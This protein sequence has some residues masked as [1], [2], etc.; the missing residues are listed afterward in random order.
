M[1]TVG[2]R[3]RV[4]KFGVLAALVACGSA[5]GGSAGGSGSTSGS[6]GSLGATTGGSAA[7]GAGSGIVASGVSVESTGA[8]GSGTSIGAATGAETTS[9]S[10]A[11]AGSTTGDVNASGTTMASGATAAPSSGSVGNGYSLVDASIAGMVGAGS[12]EPTSEPTTK[13]CPNGCTTDAAMPPMMA[14]GTPT[15]I[16]D[17]STGR[18]LYIENQCSYTIW[19][20]GGN[21]MFGG[22]PLKSGPG[23]AFV[24]TFPGGFSGRLWPRSGC[25]AGGQNCTQTGNDTLAEFTL[26]AGMDSDWYDISLVDGFTIPVGIIQ[27]S[28]PWT[29]GPGYVP[30]GTLD[31][32]T[33]QCGSPI[34]AADLDPGCH[35]SQQEKDA[36]GNVWGCKNGQSSNGGAGPTPVTEYLK[37]G[38]PTSYTY[39]YDDP[40]SLFLCKSAAQNNGVGA[41]DYKI[42]YCPTQGPVPGFP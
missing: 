31:K 32:V 40:Q 22:G 42:I 29:M 8:V 27:L 24:T 21:G 20:L 10:A 25:N 14:V 6:S 26:T 30:G 4:V 37:M 12:P 15:A 2:D 28:A 41:K 9:G 36:T 33:Q 34:C 16:G 35:V 18:K 3:A 23:T 39:P 19:T 7:V 17:V 1:V 11:A 13:D 38:C 5:N